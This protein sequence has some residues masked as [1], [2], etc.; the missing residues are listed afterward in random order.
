MAETPPMPAALQLCEEIFA[1][2]MRRRFTAGWLQC[3][4]CGRLTQ[5]SCLQSEQGCNLVSKLYR[6]RYN[7][8]AKERNGH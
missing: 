1:T 6:Q 7:A 2:N 3:F 4:V 8:G 5:Q